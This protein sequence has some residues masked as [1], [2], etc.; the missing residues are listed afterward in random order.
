MATGE[1]EDRRLSY[2]SELT[3]L[4]GTGARISGCWSL[5]SDRRW[6]VK[7]SVFVRWLLLHILK[8][9]LG[10]YII[11]KLNGRWEVRGRAGSG[12]V[13][14]DFGISFMLIMS[15]HYEN[16]SGLCQITIR[17]FPSETCYCC[18][19]ILMFFLVL[20]SLHYSLTPSHMFLIQTNL[21]PFIGIRVTSWKN[22]N[23]L[24]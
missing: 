5:R 24:L 11:C 21:I 14:G 23:I 13:S 16:I 20:W 9:I 15:Q 10:L 2:G 1:A 8:G 22:M 6:D 4:E 12:L 19:K 18:C 3:L 7:A 17:F